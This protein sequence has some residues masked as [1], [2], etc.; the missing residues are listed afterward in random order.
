MRFF[1]V[2]SISHLFRDLNASA[3]DPWMMVAAAGAAPADLAKFADADN[4][5]I[6]QG[7]FP[8]LQPQMALRSSYQVEER[9]LKVLIGLEVSENDVVR[10]GDTLLRDVLAEEGL[11]P[12]AVEEYDVVEK[13]RNA[14]E[15]DEQT[16]PESGI[17]GGADEQEAYSGDS[18]G[19]GQHKDL[20]ELMR[21]DMQE[22]PTANPASAARDLSDS[23]SGAL[24]DCEYS[25]DLDYV[26]DVFAWVRQRLTVYEMEQR[27]RMNPTYRDMEAESMKREA[28]GKVKILK[29]NLENRMRLTRERGRWLPR[30]ERL[31][32]LLKL[33]EFERSILHLLMYGSL[34]PS[35]QQSYGSG[36][37]SYSV[38]DLLKMFCGESLKEQVKYC[39]CFF[40]SAPLVAEGILRVGGHDGHVMFSHVSLDRR[41]LDYLA[42]VDSSFAEMVEGSHILT[43]TVTLDQVKLPSQQKETILRTV[44]NFQLLQQHRLSTGGL[45]LM[46]AGPSGTGK[47]MFTHAL[48]SHL[49]MSILLVDYPSLGATPVQHGSTPFRAIFREALLNNAIVFF[50]ECDALLKHRDLDAMLATGNN[51]LQQLLVEVER[52]SGIVVL[53]TNRLQDLYLD[54][55]VHRRITLLSEFAVPDRTLREAIWKAHIPNESLPEDETVLPMVAERY[56]L[57][58]GFIAQAVRVALGEAVARSVGDYRSRL[59]NKDSTSV[60][61]AKLTGADLCLGANLQLRAFIGSRLSSPESLVPKASLDHVHLDTSTATHL[62]SLVDLWKARETLVSTWGFGAADAPVRA[63][64]VGPAGCGKST[65]A[66][67]VALELGLPIRVVHARELTKPDYKLR[68]G[69]NDLV[70]V[71]HMEMIDSAAAWEVLQTT[72]NICIVCLTTTHG[73]NHPASESKEFGYVV[74]FHRPTAPV[75]EGLFRALVPPKCPVAANVDYV[76]LAAKYDLTG[77]QIKRAIVKAAATAALRKTSEERVLRMDDL[78]AAC[79]QEVA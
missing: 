66:E 43:P 42:G 47:T 52:F 68:V 57:A 27:I 38:R 20:F 39:S 54:E 1:C 11:G 31:T 61:V 56:E 51:A 71:K 70:V 65:A 29:A 49:S 25:S 12:V 73:T 8:E 30:L 18:R 48:A 28:D 59:I 17:L 62:R 63:L 36:S 75:R 5:Y 74:R 2:T 7:L 37:V 67:A 35:F 9:M 16:L 33:S 19:V 77:L 10:L 4:V 72:E 15:N 3:Y 32:T 78:V 64:F 13:E 21:Q 34:N 53:A 46:F 50:D 76:A 41:M 26:D 69:K 22:Y 6:S 23:S 14:E 44:N 24:G 40:K 60:V 58:G 79:Q 55:A 45:V